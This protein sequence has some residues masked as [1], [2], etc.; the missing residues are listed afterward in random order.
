VFTNGALRPVFDALV[1]NLPA[2]DGRED[3]LIDTVDDGVTEV[4]TDIRNHRRSVAQ[5]SSTPTSVE[6]AGGDEQTTDGANTETPPA[7]LQP[8]EPEDE[9]EDDT[10]NLVGDT[11]APRPNRPRSVRPGGF[12]DR[13]TRTINDFGDSAINLTSTDGPKPGQDAGSSADSAGS[14]AGNKDGG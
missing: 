1:N 11:K 3:G 4:A 12:V 7:P 5:Q 10:Q 8:E 9:K 13:V 2:P 6:V 14:S